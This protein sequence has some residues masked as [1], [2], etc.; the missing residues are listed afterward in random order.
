MQDVLHSTAKLKVAHGQWK[1]TSL[2]LAPDH[3]KAG[4]QIVGTCGK[5]LAVV[6]AQKLKLKTLAFGKGERW[7]C[8]ECS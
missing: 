7:E 3:F 2:A 1:E 8:G 4:T 5:C 6:P